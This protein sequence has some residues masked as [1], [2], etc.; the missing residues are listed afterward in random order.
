MRRYLGF[1][2]QDLPDRPE[3]GERATRDAVQSLQV[4]MDWLPNPDPILKKT[5]DRIGE[6]EKLLGNY[7]VFSSVEYLDSA[8][9]EYEW[10]LRPQPDTRDADLEQTREWLQALDFERIDAEIVDGRLY[11]Y[12]PFEVM[13]TETGGR[14]RPSA[15]EGKP[16]GWFAYTNENE[17][18]LRENLAR[19]A[20]L[21]PVPPLKFITARNRPSFKNPYGLS[22]LSRAFWPVQ[23]L[24]GNVRM[25]VTF[26]ER[27]GI[28][29][30]VG[31]HPP[32]YDD[33]QV[34][35][36][37]DQLENLV[38]DSV[39]AIPDDESVELLSADKGGSSEVFQALKNWCEASIQKAL[40]SSTLTTDSGEV[41]SHA[42]GGTQIENVSGA[43]VG[44]L[45]RMKHS[46]MNELLRYVWHLNFNG[47]G[48]APRFRTYEEQEPDKERAE[49]D[50]TLT[51]AGVSFE[52]QYWKRVYNLEEDDF[53]VQEPRG[54][55]R[56]GPGPQTGASEQMARD[57]EGVQFADAE[58][59]GGQIA[60]DE[61]I[62][63]L[64]SDDEQ[65]QE[66]MEELLAEPI[67]MIRD[68]EDPD[69]V[70]E[71]LARAYP[72]LDAAALEERLRS[73]FFVAEVWG[74]L[75]AEE[76]TDE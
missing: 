37:L 21:E 33:D 6:L 23:F 10:E 18:A 7:E 44:K 30:A 28:D 3:T 17:L 41:G 62:E 22:A 40:L 16:P 47:P 45:R 9:R 75:S 11:G 38:R 56:R 73:L 5:G 4:I 68:G 46:T 35:G 74:R 42:L 48:A 67:E 39:A 8:L 51:E 29:K 36:L 27:H 32:K 66:Y 19:N 76:E 61:M 70:M 50:R 54:Q 2:Q 53:E 49:R 14:W 72:D 12:Q 31:K 13:W 60:L 26:A 55:T 34:S 1:A 63:A 24:K 71:E 52:P 15:L 69:A 59:Q 58:A 25:W 57:E 64:A 43:V 20:D 65:N